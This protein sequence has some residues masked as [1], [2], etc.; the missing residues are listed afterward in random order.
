MHIIYNIYMYYK[1]QKYDHKTGFSAIRGILGLISPLSNRCR[2][3]QLVPPSHS[4]LHSTQ[5][6]L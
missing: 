1:M 5:P 2:P 6:E 3:A 4:E